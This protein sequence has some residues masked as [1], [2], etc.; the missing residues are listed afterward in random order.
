MQNRE[1]K[2][3]T[4]P[5][6]GRTA[7]TMINTQT[8][9]LFKQ[10]RNDKK[11]NSTIRLEPNTRKFI[12]IDLNNCKNI[13]WNKWKKHGF[14]IA[15]DNFKRI[16]SKKIEK[17]VQREESFRISDSEL[18]LR[19]KIRELMKMKGDVEKAQEN[20]R[21]IRLI[22]DYHENKINGFF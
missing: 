19:H 11:L 21:L 14:E 5:K 1:S 16:L 3:H 2:L 17:E 10:P 9:S 12:P 6:F 8:S 13:S 15:N 7:S 20:N 18:K 22:Q 4:L